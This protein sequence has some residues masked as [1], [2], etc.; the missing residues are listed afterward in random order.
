MQLLSC[1]LDHASFVS[2]VKAALDGV[3]P[4][5]LPGGGLVAGAVGLV[6]VCDLGYQRVVGVRVCEHGADGEEHCGLLVI[7]RYERRDRSWVPAKNM[8]TLGD[9]ERRAPLISQDVQADGSVAVNVGVVDAGGEVDL[10]RLEGVV[11][12]EVDGEEEDAAGVW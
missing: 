9:G 11:C 6:D 4:G 12:G 3:L 5:P 1:F 7:R 2:F 8:H 10:R